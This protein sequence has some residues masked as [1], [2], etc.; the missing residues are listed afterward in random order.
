MN[1]ESY[2]LMHQK[3]M[4]NGRDL[5]RQNST[6][7][8]QTE[9]VNADKRVLVGDQIH[10]QSVI[11]SNEK[12]IGQMQTLDQK[13]EQ[14]LKSLLLQQKVLLEITVKEISQFETT[15]KEQMQIMLEKIKE[16]SALINDYHNKTDALLSN[17]V[18]NWH[19][20]RQQWSTAE[21]EFQKVQKAVQ[22]QSTS[23]KRPITQW[24][25]RNVRA[26]QFKSTLGALNESD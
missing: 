15:C 14:V 11:K 19:E 7:C 24:P 18:S 25:K 23:K 26:K 12:S 1:G 3:Y 8:L 10:F 5:T 16:C 4:I 13:L 17:C 22:K 20:T 9:R 2:R 21:A 6:Y